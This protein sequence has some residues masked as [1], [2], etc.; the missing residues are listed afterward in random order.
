MPLLQVAVSSYDDGAERSEAALGAGTFRHLWPAGYWSRRPKNWP[1]VAKM[2]PN[3][4]IPTRNDGGADCQSDRKPGFL[5][6]TGKN[7]GKTEAEGT[8]LEPA[9]P[10]GAV[11]FEST[12]SPIRIPSVAVAF[13]LTEGER[14]DKVA[15][16]SGRPDCRVTR[17]N[18]AR[19]WG[20]PAVCPPDSTTSRPASSD[21]GFG[22]R[23]W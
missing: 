8:G 4:A 23:S 14:G 19:E 12:S 20:N 9:T 3:V 15:I 1:D 17:P 22:R 21:R 13:S 18:C 5:E 11:D 6:K 16:K 7:K 10:Y 2:R